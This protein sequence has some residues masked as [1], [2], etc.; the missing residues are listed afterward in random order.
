MSDREMTAH[1]KL[2]CQLGQLSPMRYRLVLVVLLGVFSCLVWFVLIHATLV[3]RQEVAALD[4]D[5]LEQLSLYKT[6]KAELAQVS[7]VSAVTAPLYESAAQL[8]S[9]SAS[10]AERA[11]ARAEQSNL[12]IESLERI[13]VSAHDTACHELYRLKA[14]GGFEAI[15]LFMDSRGYFETGFVIM[16]ATIRN[17]NWP[18]YRTLLAVDLLVCALSISLARSE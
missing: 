7:S 6:L 9:T 2:M 4:S 18:E 1:H 5:A 15:R 16:D 3:Y 11:R 13:S 14:R 8:L 12:E 10:V 17:P